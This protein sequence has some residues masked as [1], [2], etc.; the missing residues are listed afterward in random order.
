MR[1]PKSRQRF[2]LAMLW[3]GVVA[4][5]LISA[6]LYHRF[7]ELPRA[8]QPL[9][10]RAQWTAF[11][12]TWTFTETT[13]ENASDERG[14]KLIIG[15][16][17][18]KDYTVSA[19]VELEGDTGDMGLLARVEDPDE[20]VDAFRGIYAGLRLADNSLV[21]GQADYGW[22]ELQPQALAVPLQP[23]TWYHLELSIQGCRLLVVA[24]QLGG[25]PLGRIEANLD[26]C[27][28]RGQ[29]GLRSYRSGGSWRSIRVD[30]IHA[31][32]GAVR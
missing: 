9:S 2:W 10:S 28:P 20:G 16:S 32:E 26:Q 7:F 8:V 1:S 31:H 15:S 21:A 13:I 14:A 25:A 5:V 12:G 24:S 30:P 6:I 29:I 18:W 3:S 22:A 17:Y 23:F 19:D 11:G 4:A 27:S